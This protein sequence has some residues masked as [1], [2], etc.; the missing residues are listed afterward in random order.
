MDSKIKDSQTK[1]MRASLFCGESSAEGVDSVGTDFA[2]NNNKFFWNADTL[3][4]RVF[5]VS[6][7]FRGILEASSALAAWAGQE[8]A[9]SK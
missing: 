5:V 9:R 6:V 2:R 7:D 8:C 3:R 1:E 4:T